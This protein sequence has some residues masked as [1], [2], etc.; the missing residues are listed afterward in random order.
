M[1]A[2][3][4]A[5]FCFLAGEIVARVFYG[6]FA[7]FNMEMWRYAREMK[8][9]L[10]YEKLPFHHVPYHQGH[11]YGV[12]IKTNS[13]GF[14]DREY[15]IEKPK[16]KKRIILLGDSFTLGW[17]VSFEKTFAKQLETMLNRRQGAWEVI[18]MGAGNYNSTMEVELFE[19]KGLQ[20]DPDIVIL[21]YFVNDVEPVPGKE[22]GL[23]Y[24]ATKHSYCISFLAGRFIKLRSRFDSDYQWSRY[25]RSLYS[26]ANTAN[27]SA[28]EKSIRKLVR[29]CR[30]HDI[31][32][33]FV[34]IPELRDFDNYQ[35]FEATEHIRSLAREA[36]VP[37]LDLFVS[38]AVHKPESLWV[39]Q[40]DPHANEKANSI[41]AE[42]IY[43]MLIQES[44]SALLN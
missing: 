26:P 40:E 18:N 36:S 35:F 12:T 2:A 28:A 10:P 23:V 14:R 16:N 32:L 41:I 4:V 24:A 8:S 39:S 13:L 34:N 42:Q 22:S 30:R 7:D 21:V 31:S 17:G 33:L 38:F 44:H 37:F 1:F 27:I 3:Y 43:G 29:L 15:D 9:P 20:L 19:L 6:H 5:L 11:F 25:Y